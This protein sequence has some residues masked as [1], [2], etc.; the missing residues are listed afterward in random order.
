MPQ[1]IWI[2]LLDQCFHFVYDFVDSGLQIGVVILY[3]VD[4]LRQAPESVC[5]CI[6]HVPLKLLINFHELLRINITN[7]LVELIQIF[8]FLELFNLLIGSFQPQKVLF[9]DV[10]YTCSIMLH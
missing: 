6:K 4:K 3:V 10:K 9:F 8:I 1:S 7:L 5:L 2:C